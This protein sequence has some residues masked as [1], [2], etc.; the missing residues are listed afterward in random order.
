M[1]RAQASAYIADRGYHH[2]DGVRLGLLHSLWV[3]IWGAI[4]RAMGMRRPFR[5]KLMP[6]ALL[7]ASYAPAVFVLGIRIV[8]GSLSK[9]LEPSDSVYTSLLLYAQLSV[10]L[11][12]GLAAPDVLCPDRRE[13]VLSLYFVAPITRLHYILAKLTGI[14]L[15]LI[16]MTVVPVLI[17][18]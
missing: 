10:L 2:Y 7:L 1:A 17:Y 15:L 3:I 4:F 18:F 13:R 14:V 9:T 16:A 5:T 8:A 12:A 11:F 6:W